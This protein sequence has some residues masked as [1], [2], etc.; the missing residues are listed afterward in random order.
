[1]PTMAVR[2]VHAT[3]TVS[4]MVLLGADM[5]KSDVVIRTYRHN[6]NTHR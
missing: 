6:C 3:P 1:M 2:Q 4:M 5:A